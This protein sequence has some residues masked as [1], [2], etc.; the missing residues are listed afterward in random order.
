MQYDW[1]RYWVQDGG[2]PRLRNGF[3]ADPERRYLGFNMAQQDP[4]V[5]MDEI[6][7]DC[8]VLLGEPGIGKT[9]EVKALS[10]KLEA[11]TRGDHHLLHVELGLITDYASLNGEL[12][13][14]EEVEAW[15]RGE[16]N[17]MLVLDALDECGMARVSQHLSRK[18][19]S[20][21]H[22]ADRLRLRITCR[23]AKWSEALS[24]SLQ[25]FWRLGQVPTYHLAP[26]RRNDVTRAAEKWG[27][28]GE[29]F[30]IAVGEADAGA[31]AASPLTLEALLS[32]YDQEG[33]LQVGKA[34]LFEEYCRRLSTEENKDR[35][36]AGE[37]G[38]L[39]P[40]QRVNL[41][42][43]VAALMTFGQRTRFCLESSASDLANAI[44]DRD[45]V[46]FVDEVRTA[47][48]ARL[49]DGFEPS[50]EAIRD[51]VRHTGLLRGSDGGRTFRWRHRSYAEYLAARFLCNHGFSVKQV[52]P[53]IEHEYDQVVA[54]PYQ[55]IAVWLAVLDEEMM[56]YLLGKDPSF[57]YAGDLLQYGDE[58]RRNIIEAILTGIDKGDLY[59]GHNDRLNDLSKVSHCGLEEQLRRWIVNEEK[60]D[61]AR[62]YAVQLARKHAIDGLVPDA[63]NIVLN[64]GTDA[65]LRIFAIRL[66]DKLG[67]TGDR[68][69]LRLLATEPREDDADRRVAYEAREKLLPDLLSFSE[70]IEH[71]RADADQES[72]EKVDGNWY[73]TLDQWSFPIVDRMDNN[74]LGEALQ[75]SLYEDTEDYFT[76]LKRSIIQSALSSVDVIEIRSTLATFIAERAA[77]RDTIEPTIH[78][79]DL[80]RLREKGPENHRLLSR[81]VIEALAKHDVDGE[82]LRRAIVGF[83]SVSRLWSRD[84]VS[85]LLNNL[86]ETGDERVE[87]VYAAIIRSLFDSNGFS[88]V[89]GFG[90]IYEVSQESSILSK[91][92]AQWV[93]PVAL[94]SERATQ[95][96]KWHE[97]VRDWARDPMDP[98]FRVQFSEALDLCDDDIEAGWKKLCDLL[99]RA[100]IK[101]ESV[102]DYNYNRDATELPAWKE[103]SPGER[104]R[105]ID[106]GL[107][108]LRHTS[109]TQEDWWIE[110]DKRLVVTHDL[111]LGYTALWI[112]A[113]HKHSDLSHIDRE[114]WKRW[115]PAIFIYM[116]NT[117]EKRQNTHGRL[118]KVA[119]HHA[120]EECKTA[121][122]ELLSRFGCT[123]RSVS[124]RLDP[125]AE[126]EEIQNLLLEL[127]N[128]GEVPIN[129]R[130]VLTSYLLQNGVVKARPVAEELARQIES[131]ESFEDR[132]Y[133]WFVDVV[134]AAP[135]FGWSL[136]SEPFHAKD[137]FASVMIARMTRRRINLLSLP[138]ALVR[139]ILG[140]V[141]DLFPPTEDPPTKYKTH[142]PSVSEEVTKWRWTLVRTLV[143][144]GTEEAV[145]ALA[146]IASE[147]PQVRRWGRTLHRA[148]KTL[149]QRTTPKVPPRK[150]LALAD[151]TSRRIVR[152]SAELQR[153]VMEA[154]SDLQDRLDA[155]EQPAAAD[156]WNEIPY[157]RQRD[158]VRDWVQATARHKDLQEEVKE[159]KGTVCIPKDEERLSDYIARQLR[160]DLRSRGVVLTRE[161]EV[162][163]RNRTDILVKAFPMLDHDEDPLRVIIEVKGA[164][165]KDAVSSLQ[166][167]LAD[168]YLDPEDGRYGTS[169]GIYL[170]V[171]FD[172]DRW[173]RT[174]SRREKADRLESP[175]VLKKRLQEKVAELNNGT[176]KAKPRVES[177][178]LCA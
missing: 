167:Q 146:D 166:T 31:F 28:D 110:D 152:T 45:S 63:I 103:L 101:H 138:T 91:Q 168:R 16:I 60:S 154:L 133:D 32:R 175:D 86:Q 126:E 51:V 35:K 137:A 29:A 107:T 14:T 98:P 11:E 65:T 130:L 145:D 77:K 52:R 144:R 21:P 85:W 170:V 25:D 78:S 90:R 64:A 13:K 94:N 121:I 109:I 141:Y 74:M 156:L 112:L 113:R 117:S 68:E 120:P 18:L 84:D 50:T 105:V 80:K 132:K 163:V 19:F 55:N 160:D 82:T 4:L 27:F 147:F 56:R 178:V 127:Q 69:Q 136:I 15:K 26:L 2:R 177:F 42:A 158:M 41:L 143:N 71:I 169:R 134:E 135:S 81:D 89:E 140:R 139:Q 99:H 83:R 23:S 153:V 76:D 44:S 72:P 174:D 88:D 12:L 102:R 34:Q 1:T 106:A 7:D 40:E 131:D 36:A 92:I 5:R 38:A 24:K 79:S 108:Y 111:I 66:I 119:Y 48:N 75:W 172:L 30:V 173:S 150:L 129:N 116:P 171:W 165:N 176:D 20:D 61:E 43:R 124:F 125:I 53:L 164:W 73:H 67:D 47:A 161:S 62:E 118:V 59:R 57:V 17:L 122:R 162:R 93:E 54:P 8:A 87:R 46:L 3:L 70:L 115:C 97:Q 104:D 148:K 159:I 58:E 123:P 142:S 128:N 37:I 6:E 155:Q 9:T 149:R 49:N 33:D 151:D 96:Q 114:I 39:E 10:E 22:P 100:S 157:G 95:R